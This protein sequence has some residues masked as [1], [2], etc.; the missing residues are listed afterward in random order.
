MIKVVE[1]IQGRSI[2]KGALGAILI[3]IF[4]SLIFT[5]SLHFTSLS[6]SYIPALASLIFFIS[7][8]LGS[9]ISS[10]I[11]GSKGL[12]HGIGVG[13]TYLLFALIV[14]FFV[15]GDAF[16]AL[17]FIKK[18]LYALLASG[19]GGVIGVGLSHN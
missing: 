13:I 8:L 9:T 12:F 10:K 1:G 6:E 15:A 11:A 14:G 4:L 2:L 7:I 3:S 16:S 18:I 5:L 17:V 19:L